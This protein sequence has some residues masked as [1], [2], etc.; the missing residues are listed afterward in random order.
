MRRTELWCSRVSAVKN[1]PRKLSRPYLFLLAGVGLFGLSACYEAPTSSTAVPAA[2]PAAVVAPAADHGAV[3]PVEELG[4]FLA[5]PEE[6]AQHPVNEIAKSMRLNAAAMKL[7]RSVYEAHCQSCHGQDLKGG[8]ATHTPDLTDNVWRF[9]GDDLESGGLTMYP[10]DVEWTV[11]Y[12]VR[13]DNPMTKGFDVDMLAFDPRYRN[14]RDTEDF[15][16]ARTMTDAEVDDVVEYV[17]KLSGQQHDAARAARGALLFQDDSRAN[18]FDCHGRDGTGILALGST[19]L[20]RRELYLY[21]S[22]RATVRESI[23]KGR[24]GQM[25]AFGSKLKE[26]ELRAVSVYVYSRA[27]P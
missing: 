16:S 26:E 9:S 19:D 22:D 23:L 25:P 8:Q 15:G 4:E 11:R 5:Y 21:G 10:A 18:C 1:A 20:T 24:Y 7:G 3:Q 17:L 14:K 27:A 2:A 13:A 12:G 6:L